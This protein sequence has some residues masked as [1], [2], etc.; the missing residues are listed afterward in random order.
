MVITVLDHVPH[1]Y[2][3]QDGT[4]I[5]ALLRPAFARGQ[6]ITLSFSGVSD[7]PSSFINA[8][9]VPFVQAY[10]ADWVKAHL[11]LTGVTRQVAD[12]VR[13]CFAN[14]ERILEAA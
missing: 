10:G 5:L 14:A 4:V 8:S 2:T 6:R 1:C 12:M 3:P 7:V 11:V 13:R 9:L